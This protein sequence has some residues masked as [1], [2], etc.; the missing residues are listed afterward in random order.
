MLQRV[1]RRRQRLGKRSR[2]QFVNIGPRVAAV[3]IDAI[4]AVILRGDRERVGA[5]R[6]LE[7]GLDQRRLVVGSRGRAAFGNRPTAEQ[8]RR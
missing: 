3:E 7:R 8:Q 2:K 6:C 5:K 4:G 1:D